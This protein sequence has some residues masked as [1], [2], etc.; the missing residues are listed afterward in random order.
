MSKI[1]VELWGYDDWRG[2]GAQSGFFV[3]VRFYI[4]E[5]IMD[6]SWHILSVSLLHVPE[7]PGTGF[8]HPQRIKASEGPV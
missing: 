8:T 5:R 2:L 6:S 3:M 1:L 4:E 7:R